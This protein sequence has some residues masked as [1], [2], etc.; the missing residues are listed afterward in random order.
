MQRPTNFIINIRS[1]C[2]ADDSDI[3][4]KKQTTYFVVS[5]R[6]LRLTFH[7]L[8]SNGA[9][10]VVIYFSVLPTFQVRVVPSKSFILVSDQNIEGTIYAN[11]R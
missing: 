8:G 2:S 9:L 1:L 7:V 4:N 6:V 11:Y 10:T 3:R 5:G